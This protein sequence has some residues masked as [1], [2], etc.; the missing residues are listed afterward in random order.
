[1]RATELKKEQWGKLAPMYK[2]LSPKQ[3]LG[4]LSGR[5]DKC[6]VIL[7][8]ASSVDGCVFIKENITQLRSEIS[9]MKA[10]FPMK[11]DAKIL[12]IVLHPSINKAD[13]FKKIR[14][15]LYGHYERIIYFTSNEEKS[16]GAQNFKM[17]TYQFSNKEL[18]KNRA[19]SIHVMA[20]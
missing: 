9:G 14:D 13:A 20:K 15:T 17:L 11:A 1:M 4:D 10:P 19:G 16:S 5:A 3:N 8:S 12:D 2:R 7:G 6:F 18:L